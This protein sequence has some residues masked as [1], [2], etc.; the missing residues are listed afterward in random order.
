MT[1]LAYLG[2]V[3]IAGIAASLVG[4]ILGAPYDW[5]YPARE[6]VYVLTLGALLWLTGLF[7]C[8]FG[9]QG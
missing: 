8:S 4:V 1:V 9:R 2:A 7:R 5:R 6:G 3:V